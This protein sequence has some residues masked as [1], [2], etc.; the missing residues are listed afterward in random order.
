MKPPRPFG[1]PLHPALAHFPMALL[2]ATPAWDA[3]AWLSGEPLWSQMAFWSLVAGLAAAVP[4][5]ITGLMEYSALGVGHRAAARAN[6][7][8]TLM[9]TAVTLFGASALFRGA[10]VLGGTADLVAG[11]ATA[12][13]GLAALLVGGWAGADL[14]YRYGVGTDPADP[15]QANSG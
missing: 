11:V 4:V 7:H 13:L 3:A 14:V 1:H 5:L 8:M 15:P 2:A 10:E 9:S 12:V 6:L